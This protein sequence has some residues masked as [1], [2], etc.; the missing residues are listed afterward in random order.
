LARFCKRSQRLGAWTALAV[1]LSMM[2]LG[3]AVA[4]VPKNLPPDPPAAEEQTARACLLGLALQGAVRREVVNFQL[5]VAR[6]KQEDGLTS[7]LLFGLRVLVFQPKSTK[8]SAAGRL[9]R[10]NSAVFVSDYYA[11]VARPQAGELDDGSV[12]ASTFDLAKGGDLLEAVASGNFRIVITRSGSA[13]E[14]TYK[15][16]S[17]P[18]ME[19][20]AEFGECI[21]VFAPPESLYKRHRFGA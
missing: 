15:P 9:I 14:H 16:P 21:E 3:D 4:S 17:P 8:G 2:S 6:P 11:A 7:P 19:A 12:F 5:V 20:L 18:P 1:T 10:I 13:V